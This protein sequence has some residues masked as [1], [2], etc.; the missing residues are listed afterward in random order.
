MRTKRGN[1]CVQYIEIADEVAKDDGTFAGQFITAE[2][3]VDES[4]RRIE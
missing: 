2:E 3:V 4:S 1:K